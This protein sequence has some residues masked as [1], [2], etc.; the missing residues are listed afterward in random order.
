[1]FV[2]DTIPL[3]IYITDSWYRY[4][5]KIEGFM[6]KKSTISEIMSLLSNP[7]IP[8]GI[9]SYLSVCGTPGC[10][11]KDK[12]D[13]KKH[14][15]YNKLSYSV[16]GKSSSMFIKTINLSEAENMVGNFKR[17]KELLN[18][19]ALEN[20]DILR[21][22]NFDISSLPIINNPD[23]SIKNTD[24]S[25]KIFKEKAELRNKVILSNKGKIR[26]LEKSRIE[27]KDKAI[28]RKSELEN[29]KN[30]I[31]I[32]KRDDLIQKKKTAEKNP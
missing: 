7:I 28:N 26:D 23:L 13:P 10:R 1:M 31:L 6:H 8:G 30:E 4:R 3:F 20:I 14:G 18:I 15:P 9:R 21:T 5:F 17:I 11:C 24:V 19:L 27:W 12:K 29:L 32:L 16:G 25:I 22:N 2:I